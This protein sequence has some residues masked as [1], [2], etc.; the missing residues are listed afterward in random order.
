MTASR[1]SVIRRAIHAC[2]GIASILASHVDAG[3]QERNAVARAPGA[4]AQSPPI[5]TKG[6]PKGIAG[7]I[8]GVPVSIGNYLFAKRV[9][10]TFPSPWGA[11]DLPPE[12]R[13]PVIWENLIL[14]YEAFRRGIT[15]TEEE[16]NAAVDH[17]LKDQ[18]QPF[19]RR[20][21]ADAYRR[22][23]SETL[24]EEAELFENQI[25]YLVQIRK[26]KH[27]VLQQQRVTVTETEMQ[28]GFLNDQHHVGGELVGLDTKE[29]ADAF[30]QAVKGPNGWDA[31]KDR[32]TYQ[33]RLVSPM[34]LSAIFDLW[35]VPKDQIHAFHAMRPGSIGSPM[36]FGKKWGVF[37]LL[38]K[39]TGDLKDFP[40]ERDVYSRKVEMKKKH[41]ALTQWVEELKSSARLKTLV[42]PE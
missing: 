37:R 22:W 30:Y 36:P 23:V 3:A 12:G 20:G 2:L 18:G 5:V 28:Q 9:A 14:H 41:H 10:Y 35:G 4:G 34:T 42:R 38:E 26:L 21:D 24:S 39:R 13:E 40:A 33:V 1:H 19:S 7:E 27:Q 17:F 32:G 6:E 16:L 29:A 25:R 15:V 11:A 8:F 31:M